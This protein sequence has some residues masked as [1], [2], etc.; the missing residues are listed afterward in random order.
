[1]DYN[2][3]SYKI[4]PTGPAVYS[5]DNPRTSAPANVGGNLSVATFNVLNYFSTLDGNGRIC[6]PVD[7]L[8]YCRGA[9]NAEEF[10]RQRTK[11][12]AAIAAIN[13]DVV[14]LM[15]IENYKAGGADVP[16]TDL[17]DGVNA[18]VGAGTYAAVETGPIGS[19]AI[20]VV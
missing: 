17:V 2:F 7:N 3:G 12:I 19:D 4:Q 9:D 18:V 20:K 16:L 10:E 6:G 13:A 15:E 8:Q 5:A 14:G 11:I 1:M